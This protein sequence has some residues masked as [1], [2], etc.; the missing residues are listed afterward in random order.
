LVPLHGRH[1][2]MSPQGDHFT[3]RE[4]AKADAAE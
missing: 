3:L 4:A 2:R 1:L